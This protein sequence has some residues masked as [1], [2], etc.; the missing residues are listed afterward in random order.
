MSLLGTVEEQQVEKVAAGLHVSPG[1]VVRRMIEAAFSLE[2]DKR[3]FLEM[4][5][6]YHGLPHQT[7]E[8]SLSEVSL[9]PWEI[10]FSQTLRNFITHGAT[11]GEYWSRIHSRKAP[12][13]YLAYS[14]KDAAAVSDVEASL[15]KSLEEAAKPFYETATP[16]ECIAAFDEWTASHVGMPFV[17]DSAFSREADY[18]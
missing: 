16:E 9:N 5:A 13:I 15:S 17:P 2:E 1:D 18:E 8:A 7:Q 3:L 11:Y 10:T 6:I 14:S 4:L 12:E